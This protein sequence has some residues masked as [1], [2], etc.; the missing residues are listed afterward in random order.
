MID[1]VIVHC[2]E[3]KLTVSILRNKL[4]EAFGLGLKSFDNELRPVVEAKIRDFKAGKYTEKEW[5]AEELVTDNRSLMLKIRAKMRR[6][7]LAAENPGVSN[8][9]TGYERKNK[10]IKITESSKSM[11]HV[12]NEVSP[13]LQAIVGEKYISRTEMVRNVWKYIREHNLQDPKNRREIN[14]DETMKRV[15]GEHTDIFQMNRHYKDHIIGPVKEKIESVTSNSEGDSPTTETDQKPSEEDSDEQSSDE[16]GSDEQDV[17][18]NDV[19]EQA[20][21]EQDTDEVNSDSST[22]LSS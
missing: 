8:I 9:Q 13:E 2:R 21:D 6:D 16:Q 17:D 4:N 11:I 20:S 3:E 1:S 7:K 19:D 22:D 18:G 12:K 5:T 15:F 14:C 10:K